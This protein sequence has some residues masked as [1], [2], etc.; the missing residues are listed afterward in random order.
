MNKWTAIFLIYCGSVCY[1][2]A[3]FYHLSFG[4]AWSFR[5]AYT[6]AIVLVS[7][8]YLFNVIGTSMPIAT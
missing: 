4:E 3:S 7:I 8:E 1:T 6:L 5:R 2:V